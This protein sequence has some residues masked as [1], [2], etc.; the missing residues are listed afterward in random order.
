MD[1]DSLTL[2]ACWW[3]RTNVME[4]DDDD[5]ET[6]LLRTGVSFDSLH[7]GRSPLL[8][9]VNGDLQTLQVME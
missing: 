4:P 5:P 7:R 1:T 8:A 9:E 3:N 2:L 6:D